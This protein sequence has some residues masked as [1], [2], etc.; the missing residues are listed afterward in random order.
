MFKWA[1]I[2]FPGWFKRRYSWKNPLGFLSWLLS[3][4]TEDTDLNVS[5]VGMP[6][7]Y[8]NSPEEP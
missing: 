1:F 3:K 4:L 8:L 6:V 7:N 5:W 2:T